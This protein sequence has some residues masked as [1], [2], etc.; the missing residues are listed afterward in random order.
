MLDLLNFPLTVKILTHA[1]DSSGGA[2]MRDI[3]W[4]LY[5]QHR[6]AN[7]WTAFSDLSLAERT[8]VVQLILMPLEQRDR[9]LGAIFRETGEL[10]PTGYD[11]GR[12][13]TH[14]TRTM[15]RIEE[16]RAEA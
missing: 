5:N 13:D 12:I 9:T 4:S 1:W 2:A 10:P 11:G 16:G 3:L 6:H 7:L 15:T 8:E 14:P